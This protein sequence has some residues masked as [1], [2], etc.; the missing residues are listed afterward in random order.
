MMQRVVDLMRVEM[1]AKARLDL[2]GSRA[3]RADARAVAVGGLIA[4]DHQDALRFAPLR[5]RRLEECGLSGTRRAHQ[6]DR[7]D[8]PFGEMSAVVLSVRRVRCE[9]AFI[10]ID[11]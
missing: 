6:V 11:G 7:E 1:A 8:F 2:A 3:R 10:D 4:F 9:Q 5:Y